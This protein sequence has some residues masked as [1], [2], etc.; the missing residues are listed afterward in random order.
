[1][2]LG[3]KRLLVTERVAAGVEDMREI[4]CGD[5]TIF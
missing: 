4:A 5:S 1:M 2:N 3:K